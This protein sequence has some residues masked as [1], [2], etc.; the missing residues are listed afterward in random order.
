MRTFHIN[1]YIPVNLAPVT[2][3][4]YNRPWHTRRTI[5]SLQLNDLAADSDL[6]I[7]ADGPK[8]SDH[9]GVVQEVREFIR[10]IG[11]FKSITVIEREQNL[12]LARS[13]IF[14]V[15]EVVNKFGRIIVLEDD[16]VTSRH[17]LQFMNR[18]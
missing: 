10:G 6:F 17:F 16:L 11:G 9:A 18:A 2:L 4:V 13:I 12:G 1:R 14:G 3:F 7:Y 5:E 8:S 15:S